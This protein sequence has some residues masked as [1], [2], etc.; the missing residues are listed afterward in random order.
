M[1]LSRP[2][3]LVAC[4]VQHL[5]CWYFRLTMNVRFECLHDHHHHH[6]HDAR[7]PTVTGSLSELRAAGASAEDEHENLKRKVRRA[8]SLSATRKPACVVSRTIMF[9]VP[10][11]LFLVLGARR[12]LAAPM[13]LTPV[14]SSTLPEAPCLNSAAFVPRALP[15]TGIIVQDGACCSTYPFFLASSC[16]NLKLLGALQVQ[17]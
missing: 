7:Q 3:A 6:H 9:T 2:Q 15:G 4:L 11:L 1:S 10:V 17:A 13:M 12:A 8:P 14:R 5:P 16:F